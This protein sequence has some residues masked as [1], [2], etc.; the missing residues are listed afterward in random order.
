MSD[1]LYGFIPTFKPPETFYKSFVCADYFI[2]LSIY[3]YISFQN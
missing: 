2:Y 3:T 1:C